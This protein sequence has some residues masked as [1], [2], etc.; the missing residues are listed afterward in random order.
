MTKLRQLQKKFH[1]AS[2][3]FFRRIPIFPRL[4]CVM[5]LLTVIPATLVT[6][7][8]F[9]SYVDEIKE[10]TEHFISLLVGNISVQVK[11]RQETYEQSA[12]AFYSD[13]TIMALLA[14][15]A[16]LAQSPDF[17]SN[18][19]YAQNKHLVERRL[20]DMTSNSKYVQNLQF[21]TEYDQYCMR[22]SN[23]EQRG[24]V[25]HDLQGFLHSE[26][27]RKTLFE[28]GYPCWFDTTLTD[29]LIYKYDSSTSGIL[30]TLTMTVAVYSPGSRELLGILMYNLDRRFLTQSLTS[31][32]FYGTGNTFLLSRDSVIGTLN[33]N[34]KA[35]LLSD[36]G[37]IQARVLA[38]SSGSF[39]LDDGGRS[40][41]VSFKKS[42][43]MDLYIVHIVDIGTLLAPAYT[44][45]NRCL[46]L[47]LLV[48][49]LCIVLAR[50][51]ARSIS[52]PLHSLVE[53]M[54]R[55]GRNE[56]QERCC[57]QGHDELTVVS[58]GFNQMAQDTERMVGE[59]VTA[60]LRQKTLEL[61][62]T[63]A[64]LNALQMQIRPHFLYNTLD[65]IRWEM[66][67]IIGDESSASHMLDSFCRLMRM[68]IKKGE[69]FVPVAAELEHAQVYIDVANFR[70]A[71]KI[72]LLTS[73]EFD[74][75]AFLIPKLTLQ[76]LIENTVVHGFKKDLRAPAVH[77]RGWQIKDML[78]IT[79][80]DNGRGMPSGELEQLRQ[81]LSAGE[82]LEGSSIGL[83][84]V[85]QRFKLHYGDFYGVSVESVQ[86]MGTEITL[87]LPLRPAADFKEE[88]DDFS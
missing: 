70:N 81:N 9:R 43:K 35:P 48:L 28:K 67:R 88:G 20:F 80:T 82:I 26:Y 63:T 6:L 7:I 58:A 53:S 68:S 61:S 42:P 21:I 13:N 40:L 17:L 41:F 83:R 36:D 78:M 5:L 30:D 2:N 87:R 16:R 47:V 15:N 1:A 11:E 76:P 32:A 65:L 50:Y 29:D 44:I 46:L 37:S 23:N 64:E 12:R 51:T 33:P 24:C 85:N 22:N 86:G 55:F 77:I 69:E 62:K 19:E 45:R 18:S 84:N 31:Y 27:Y 74:T 34:L 56:F 71:E 4:F 57:V 79:V 75:S 73:L 60:N 52:D 14:Q 72:Q 66:I 8:S 54:D 59:I 39:T 25:L 49:V 3:N 10:N 38:G